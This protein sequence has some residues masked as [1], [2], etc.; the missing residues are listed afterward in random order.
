[1]RS[2]GAVG[3]EEERGGEVGES[4]EDDVG[5]GGEEFV[6]LVGGGDS[7]GEHSGGLCG[8]DA[9]GRIFDDGAV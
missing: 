2:A 7:D 1:M 4:G 8:E 6:V 3:V 9:G 5:A